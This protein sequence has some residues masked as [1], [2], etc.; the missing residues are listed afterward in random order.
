MPF[1]LGVDGELRPEL[2]GSDTETESNSGRRRG[3]RRKGTVSTI[4]SRRCRC[5]RPTASNRQR[6]R[7]DSQIVSPTEGQAAVAGG[8]P[9]IL[10]SIDESASV[11]TS[12]SLH[13][14]YGPSRREGGGHG[15][16]ADCTWV[17]SAREAK[18]GWIREAVK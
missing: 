12:N 2:P 16:F 4:L 13:G 14:H 10:G 15:E 1:E 3:P 6:R 17:C 11:T 18:S 8:G 7:G 5:G 9:S